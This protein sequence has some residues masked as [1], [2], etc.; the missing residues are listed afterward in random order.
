MVRCCYAF[1]L[2]LSTCQ[3]AGY[4]GKCA[5]G[6]SENNFTTKMAH[7]SPYTFGVKDVCQYN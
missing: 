2:N 5:R 4:I 3:L 1:S 7:G 6:E